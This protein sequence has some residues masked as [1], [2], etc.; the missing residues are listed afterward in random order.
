LENIYA[1]LSEW[2]QQGSPGG[3]RRR[4]LVIR[5]SAAEVAPAVM[6]AVGTTIISFLPVFFLTGRDYRLFAPLAWTKT[7]ALVASLV[8]AVAVVPM[9]CRV[10]LR[11]SRMSL[12]ASLLLG[13]LSGAAG[14]GATLTGLL[15][16]VR[17]GLGCGDLVF[18]T[19][20]GVVS[21]VLMFLLSRER[22]RPIEENPVSRLLRWVYGGRLRFA[23][24]YKLLVLSVPA[25]VLV[26]GAGAWFGLGRVLRPVEHLA[27][28]VGA[29]LRSLP[30]YQRACEVLPGLESDNWIALDEGSWFYMPSL[31]PAASFS[32]A[33][34]V[35]QSQNALIREIPEVE[36]VLGKIGRAQ[37]A[38]D[39]APASMIETYVMLKPR[40]QWRAG[41]TERGIWDAVNAVA[42]LPGVTPASALQPI[43]GRVVMLQAGIKAA[44]AVRIYG[45]S[46]E[47]L[48][49]AALSTADR[50]R[51]H[52]L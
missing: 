27:A 28:L 26:L 33:M 51:R 13:V 43:E 44:M 15:E 23:L 47:G 4:L 3:S 6:T 49:A 46:L 34:E 1:G 42:T 32:Q 38:L 40:A 19:G 37:T 17:L 22:I 18:A 21:A 30:G 14:A 41:M 5:E 39:P 50:L 24:R 9:L 12:R 10:L 48:S 8:V 35:L 7:F 25:V 11:S 16:E 29:D 2:E 45:D 36:H 31:Y 20:S 52:P